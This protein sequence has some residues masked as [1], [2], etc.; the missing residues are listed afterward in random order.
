MFRFYVHPACPLLLLHLERAFV[1]A[2][3]VTVS[4]ERS[5][6]VKRASLDCANGMFTV[7]ISCPVVNGEREGKREEEKNLAH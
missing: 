3:I 6:Q 7:T 1:L 4:S 5:M 2:W